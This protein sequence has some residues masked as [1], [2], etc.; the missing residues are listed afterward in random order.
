MFG[1]EE[2]SEDGTTSRIVNTNVAQLCMSLTII[3]K[4]ATALDSSD[5][6]TRQIVK[7]DVE[8]NGS[9]TQGDIWYLQQGDDWRSAFDVVP[10]ISFDDGSDLT[11]PVDGKTC[12]MYGFE[13]IKSKL[14]GREY[15]VL[16][17]QVAQHRLAEGWIDSYQELYHLSQDSEDHQQ[18]GLQDQEDLAHPCLESGST[19]VRAL[20]HDLQERLCVASCDQV[21]SLDQVHGQHLSAD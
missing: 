11:V 16:P 5:I 3:A 21:W 9:D 12:Y 14:I 18:P 4:E 2:V 13:D 1:H 6:T 8:L 10:K 15:Q 20:L 17:T 19:G 7:F